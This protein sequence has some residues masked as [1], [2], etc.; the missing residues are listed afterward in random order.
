MTGFEIGQRVEDSRGSKLYTGTVIESRGTMLRDTSVLVLW[1][2]GIGPFWE[3]PDN[4]APL[5]DK[6]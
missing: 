5:E 1:D 4:L 2:D 3:N 6:D